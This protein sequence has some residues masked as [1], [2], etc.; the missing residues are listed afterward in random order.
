MQ[1]PKRLVNAFNS[2]KFIFHTDTTH[3]ILNVNL[4][5][6]RRWLTSGAWPVR[7]P[8]DHHQKR[9]WRKSLSEVAQS[10]R[11]CYP[12]RLYRLIEVLI[13]QSCFQHKQEA[14]AKLLSW[15]VSPTPP[16]EHYW[17]NVWQD[18]RE[19]P[20][21]GGIC[22]LWRWRQS[23]VFTIPTRGMILNDGSFTLATIKCLLYL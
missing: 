2:W 23:N 4:L 15:H 9:L 22:F 18:C 8:H 13:I 10:K 12:N 19:V 7:N 16:G 21:L 14:Y 3:H 6:L 11:S 17:P 1:L 5:S 20:G